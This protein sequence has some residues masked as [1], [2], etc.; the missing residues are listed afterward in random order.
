M[1]TTAHDVLQQFCTSD[2][3]QRVFADWRDDPRR[4][5]VVPAVMEHG[6][7]V[8]YEMSPGDVQSVCSR[9]E[10]ALGLVRREVGESVAAIVDWHPDFAFTHMFHLCMEHIGH[11]PTYQEFREFA[12]TDHLGMRMLGGPSRA[13]VREVASLGVPED[14]ARAA[15]RWRVGNA[16]YSFLREVVTVV[17]LRHLGVDVRVH[18]LADAL[19]RVDAWVGRKVLSLLISNRKFRQGQR[20]GRKVRPELW[21]ADVFPP[22]EFECIELRPAT[23]FGHVHVPSTEHLTEVADRLRAAT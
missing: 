16:Y 15:M 12:D 13:K 8:V 11:L 14:R 18:P 1:R 3:T 2:R 20:H 17:T 19:F 5:D 22:M 6:T 7:S 10:H 23:E 9:T 21:L 4:R